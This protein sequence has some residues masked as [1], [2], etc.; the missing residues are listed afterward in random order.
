MGVGDR[1]DSG[2]DMYGGALDVAVDEVNLPGV[3]PRPDFMTQAR[4]PVPRSPGR[5]KGRQD[6]I[7]GGPSREIRDP[8]FHTIRSGVLRGLT[9]MD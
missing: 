2:G 8:F 6:S 4:N 1:R 9:A 3:Q 7:T 5:F